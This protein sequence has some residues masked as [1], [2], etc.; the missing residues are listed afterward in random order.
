M[1]GVEFGF[2]RSRGFGSARRQFWPF[3]LE[4]PARPYKIAG[5]ARDSSKRFSGYISLI[6]GPPSANGLQQFL[7]HCVFLSIM[8]NFI[9][10][11]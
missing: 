1:N 4:R 10:I 2:D 5:T 3:A 11:G 9:L 8:Q 7:A 6:C